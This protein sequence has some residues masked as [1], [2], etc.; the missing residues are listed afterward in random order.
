MKNDKKIKS[1]S[2]P[3]YTLTIEL[4]AGHTANFTYSSFELAEAHYVQLQATQFIGSLGIRNIQR[5]WRQ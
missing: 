5:S 4:Q 3:V 1:T 2:E